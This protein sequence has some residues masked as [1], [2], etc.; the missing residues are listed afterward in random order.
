MKVQTKFRLSR[1]ESDSLKHRP[2]EFIIEKV[3]RDMANFTIKDFLDVSVK[4]VDDLEVVKE[5]SSCI[6]VITEEK[7]RQIYIALSDIRDNSNYH[8]NKMANELI[9]MIQEK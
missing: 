2:E 3:K 5:Y 8:I 4:D 1:M 6:H 9:Q 7:F